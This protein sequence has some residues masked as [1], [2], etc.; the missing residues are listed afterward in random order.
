MLKK[1]YRPSGHPTSI[2][3]GALCFTIL[4]FYVLWYKRKTSDYDQDI[5][6]T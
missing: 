4:F 2:W 5:I 3:L 1:E 6:I